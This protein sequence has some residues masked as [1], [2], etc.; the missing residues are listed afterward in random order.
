MRR[1]E[2]TVAICLLIGAAP[3]RAA[4]PSELE[5]LTFLVGE[6]RASGGGEPG[7]GTGS[8]TFTRGLQDRVILR[9]NYADYPAAEGRPASRH[10]DLMVI[11]AG[12]RGGIRAD[13]YDNEGHVIHYVVQT[14]APRKAVFVS[15]AAGSEPRFRLSYELGSTGELKGEFAIA[16]PDSPEAFRRYLSWVSREATTK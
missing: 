4:V 3:L 10:D 16:P 8:A 13:Y 2:T 12:P 9:T 11:Y 14:P 15:E 6:W 7:Q 1:L 5:P